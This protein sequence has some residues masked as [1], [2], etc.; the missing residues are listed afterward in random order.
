[1]FEAYVVNLQIR[2]QA[3]LFYLWMQNQLIDSLKRVFIR[4]IYDGLLFGPDNTRLA[5]WKTDHQ[6]INFFS[7]YIPMFLAAKCS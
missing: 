7:L 2:L 5:I 6:T 4:T 1:V 3:A